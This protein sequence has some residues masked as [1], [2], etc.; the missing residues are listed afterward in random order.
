MHA[1]QGIPNRTNDRIA[2]LGYLNQGLLHT[3]GG[4]TC[5][6]RKTERLIENLT[7][8]FMPSIHR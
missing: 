6:S 3:V 8:N 1:S 4:L 5:I 2:L 7:S